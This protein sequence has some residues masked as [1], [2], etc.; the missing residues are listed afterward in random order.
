MRI[1][2]GNSKVSSLD[3]VYIRVKTSDLTLYK[4]QG[5]LYIYDAYGIKCKAFNQITSE[6]VDIYLE[7]SN[8]INAFV[9]EV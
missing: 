4:R 9:R 7:Y 2:V 6:Y 8:E 1:A 5:T 3:E